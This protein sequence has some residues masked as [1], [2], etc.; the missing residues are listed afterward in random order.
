MYDYTN[1]LELVQTME[2]FKILGI[3]RVAIYKT[4]CD[5]TVQKVLDYYVMQKFVEIIPWTISSH[6][7][8][9]RGWKNWESPGELHYFG[10]IP[11]LND[12]VY[13]YM[14]QSRYVALQDLDEIILPVPV[15]LENWTE[16]LRELERKYGRNVGFE[17]ENNFFPLTIKETNPDYSPDSWKNVVGVNILKY[18]KKLR[19]DPSKFNNFKV[20]V[21]PR[22]V[23]RSTVHGLLQ[24][25]GGTIRVDS[26][27]AH[28]YR[29]RNITFN[30][31]ENS[32][33]QDTRLRDYAGRLI[34]AISNVLTE[35]LDVQRI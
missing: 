27:I 31:P 14:Y 17:F 11:A 29:F 5:P 28:L 7:K 8:V 18:M 13:R 23:Y 6:L 3:Q 32:L 15:S 21:N 1:V 30:V 22:L 33:I 25:V 10:Q 35:V 20:I 34:P 26:N 16:L 2:M 19:I 9:S 4:N 12:C 24:S